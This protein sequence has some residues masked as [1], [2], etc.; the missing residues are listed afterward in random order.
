MGFSCH[1]SGLILTRNQG[2]STH[3]FSATHEID[4]KLDSF[5]KQMPQA[6]WEISTAMMS[7][8]TEEAIAQF[9]RM[10][11]QI[12]H[13]ELATL[14]HLP[15]MLRVATNQR[16]EYSRISCLSANRGLTKR[17]ISIREIP[18]KTR[19]AISSNSKHSRQRQRS[20]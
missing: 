6:W 16:H 1:I 5:A 8:H 13:F 10:M 17:W 20:F 3:A 19:S 14:L 15:F 4:E 12:W 7:N 11:C 18:D 9:E 2:E